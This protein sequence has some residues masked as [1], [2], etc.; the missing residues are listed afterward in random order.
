MIELSVGGAVAELVAA[1]GC[2]HFFLLT[3][4]DNAFFAE[5]IDRGV[6]MILARSERSAAFMADA[7]ARVTSRP[8]FVYGQFGPGATVV[9]SG[10]IDAH[11]AHTPVV[12]IASEAKTDVI[13]RSSYQELDQQA[14]Y[15]AFVK[16]GARVERA[17]RAPDLLRR[18]LLEAVSGCPGPTYLGIPND[19]MLARAALNNDDLY[20]DRERTVIPSRRYAGSPEDVLDVV[21]ALAEAECPVILAG[22]GTVIAEA[23]AELRELADALGVPVVTSASGKGAIAETHE[24]AFGVSGRYSRTSANSIIRQADL[25]VAVGTRLNDMTSDRGRSFAP[26]VRVAQIDVDET[27]VGLNTRTYASIVGDAAT[28]LAQLAAAVGNDASRMRD[29]WSDWRASCQARK[30]EWLAARAALENAA[31]SQTP[32][33]PVAVVAT[34]RDTLSEADYVVADTGY[35]AAW[36]SALYDVHQAGKTHLRTAG[37]LGWAVPA[38][39]GVQLAVDSAVV[40]VTGDGGLGYHLAE[41]E[42]A[43]RLGLP[44]VFVLMN[45]GTLAFEYQTQRKV[46]KRELRELNDFAEVDYA[47]C[48]RALGAGGRRVDNPRELGEALREALDAGRPW[49][50]DVRT[51]RDAQAPVTNFEA[52]EERP[53]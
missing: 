41:I 38:S 26:G 25:I 49:L 50:L 43:A 9:L 51:D 8:S 28:V 16:W 40:C 7:Y 44:V 6:A 21:R 52:L 19:V 13:H 53:L 32:I 11:L 39:L 24:L 10:L 30:A 47:A 17:D 12:A 42:T 33:S 48:A 1:S 14:M 23:Y 31:M 15:G 4:G 37:S 20:L 5:L 35:M 36:T 22:G 3:G 46:L 29:R 45:N 2:E 18:A 27:V 34:L